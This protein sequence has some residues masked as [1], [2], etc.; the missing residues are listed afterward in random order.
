MHLTSPLLLVHTL[1][2]LLYTS[3]AWE[4]VQPI[5]KSLSSSA[6]LLGSLSMSTSRTSFTQVTGQ[7]SV[8]IHHWSPVE[9]RP[10]CGPLKNSIECRDPTDTDHYVGP[11]GVNKNQTCLKTNKGT[12]WNE[13]ILFLIDFTVETPSMVDCRLSTVT[14]S[15][16][17][18]ITNKECVR[19]F[20]ITQ[21]C[22]IKTEQVK[23]VDKKITTDTKQNLNENDILNL[24]AMLTANNQLLDGRSFQMDLRT[25]FSSSLGMFV[26]TPPDGM[27]SK[28]ARNMLGLI[29]IDAIFTVYLDQLWSTGTATTGDTGASLGMVFDWGWVPKE[30]TPN[31]E[32]YIHTGSGDIQLMSTLSMLHGTL[33]SKP[34]FG[35]HEEDGNLCVVTTE[36]P[37]GSAWNDASKCAMNGNNGNTPSGA[38]DGCSKRRRT[39]SIITRSS[40]I[41]H[42]STRTT[43]M[44]QRWWRKLTQDINTQDNLCTNNGIQYYNLHDGECTT[45]GQ[46]SYTNK[47]FERLACCP[48]MKLCWE[49][50][51]DR[52]KAAFEQ[53][54]GSEK[55][56]PASVQVCRETCCEGT[57][58]VGK[59][60]AAVHSTMLEERLYWVVLI[61]VLW[62]GSVS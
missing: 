15:A 38:T 21:E 23:F 50:R 11:C 51:S 6:Q 10:V 7:L 16:T 41:M 4:Y 1:L 54:H 9:D 2:L 30:S 33:G 57:L 44:R 26:Q 32:N 58:G 52:G 46:D 12:Y 28:N 47:D 22:S 35:F 60:G 29:G 20:P 37:S 27:T 25:M 56:V 61:V 24:E 18:R 55:E 31:S 19:D 8:G 36:I 34:C 5:E 42:S 13:Q 59:C 40:S 48:G 45:E 14:L 53:K 43:L 17:V 39:K 49:Q 62:V 3:F